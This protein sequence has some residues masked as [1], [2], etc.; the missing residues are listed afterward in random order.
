MKD[1]IYCVF[2]KMLDDPIE[3]DICYWCFDFLIRGSM[4]MHG[5][6]KHKFYGG[7]DH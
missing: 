7:T 4:R 3:E 5:E 2:D 1:T 6:V